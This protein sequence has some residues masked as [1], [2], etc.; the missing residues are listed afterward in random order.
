MIGRRVL[1]VAALAYL[2]VMYLVGA[3]PRQQQFVAFEAAGVLAVTPE[4]VRAVILESGAR[5]YTLRRSAGGWTDG[6]N[7]LDANLRAELERGLKYLHTA[8][9]VRDIE[10]P[11]LAGT[12]REPFGLAPPWLT[13][14]V[15]LDDAS[16]LRL[17][18]GAPNNDDTLDYV[19]VASRGQLVLT[20]RFF[21]TQWR[22][23]QEMLQTSST[24]H[25]HV[26][27]P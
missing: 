12:A 18:F 20:S 5:R 11:A 8:R 7:S 24:D 1:P 2:L 15:E 13:L 4:H 27:Q 21:A 17:E 3:P 23:V 22:T 16:E 10:Q 6:E 14:T 26:R 25:L 19:H 9:P